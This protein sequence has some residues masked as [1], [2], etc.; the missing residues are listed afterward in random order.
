MGVLCSRVIRD[1]SSFLYGSTISLGLVELQWV[2]SHKTMYEERE[3]SCGVLW[4]FNLTGLE[5]AY[6]TSIHIPLARTQSSHIAAPD[7]KIFWEMWSSSVF[8]KKK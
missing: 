5:I 4:G 6:I 2:L 8:R 7:Y 3:K 1:F